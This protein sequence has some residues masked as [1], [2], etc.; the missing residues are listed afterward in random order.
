MLFSCNIMQALNISPKCIERN[1]KSSGWKTYSWVSW[2]WLKWTKKVN[3][4][5]FILLTTL[6]T[7]ALRLVDNPLYLLSNSHP[8][9]LAQQYY[10]TTVVTTMSL[11]VSST[12][13]VSVGRVERVKSSMKHPELPGC[14]RSVHRLWRRKSTHTFIIR[15]S[16]SL[17]V[18][19]HLKFLNL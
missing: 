14:S 13:W 18:Q 17:V 12:H 11:C 10:S 5:V 16:V 15:L 9:S 7:L 19:L 4:L 8:N 1:P 2:H 6:S 3:G